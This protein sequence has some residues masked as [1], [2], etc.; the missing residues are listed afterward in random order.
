MLSTE[1]IPQVCK[2][3]VGDASRAWQESSELDVELG[4][5]SWGECLHPVPCPLLPLAADVGGSAGA[6]RPPMPWR[7]LL[8]GSVFGSIGG[9]L[10]Q[11][12][13]WH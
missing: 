4:H 1:H 2:T 3:G 12:A 5:R 11:A 9:V 6:L 13:F 8:K 10:R 7:L